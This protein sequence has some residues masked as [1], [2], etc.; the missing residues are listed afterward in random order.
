MEELKS[1]PGIA[2]NCMSVVFDKNFFKKDELVRSDTR[3]GSIVCMVISDPTCMTSQGKC[4]LWGL[5]YRVLERIG[6]VSK[7]VSYIVKPI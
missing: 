4:K 1:T 7:E 5:K 6:K 2:F 3:T